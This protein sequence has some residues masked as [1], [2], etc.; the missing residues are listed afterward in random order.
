MSFLKNLFN[1]K[2]LSKSKNDTIISSSKSNKEI[3]E[4]SLT[5]TQER[6]V[7]DLYTS[8]EKIESV[9]VGTQEWMLKNLDVVTFSNGV[10]IEEAKT[11]ADWKYYG[12]HRIPA[13]RNYNG[14]VLYGF[15]YGKLYNWYAVNDPRGIAPEGWHVATDAEWKTL[16]EYLGGEKIAGG[17]LKDTEFGHWVYRSQA[18]N[19]SKFSAKAGGV[20]NEGGVCYAINEEGNWWTATGWEDYAIVYCIK[21]QYKNIFRRNINNEAG[22]SVRC[23][24]N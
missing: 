4:S 19:E 20:C 9:K 7:E 6:K 24:R 15:V 5:D 13:W 16:I 12:E 14:D 17:K 23:I 3:I 18:T 21:H 10:P 2:N 22:F 8:K 1:K 11:D